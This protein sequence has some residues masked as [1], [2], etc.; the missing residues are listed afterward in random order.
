MKLYR[1]TRTDQGCEVTV[2][3]DGVVQPLAPRL[4]MRSHSAT[5][6]EWGYG[7]SGPAQLALALAA[8]LLGDDDRAQ[9]VYQRLKF[10]VVGGLPR[11]GWVLTEGRLRAAVE[12]IERER[13]RGR[14]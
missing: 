5:G 6:F 7:G 3:E 10:K 9:D 13:D 11:D 4:D 2:E 1:G 14:A 12:A 8:D